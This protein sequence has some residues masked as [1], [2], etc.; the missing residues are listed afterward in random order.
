[1]PI[2]EHRV[3]CHHCHGEYVTGD[4]V[5]HIC[6]D[7]E[8]AGHRGMGFECAVCFQSDLARSNRIIME[9]QEKLDRIESENKRLRRVISAIPF[10]VTSKRHRRAL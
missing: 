2:G 3:L 9:M 7:C 6:R 4:C 8:I 5:T 1:M 10:S